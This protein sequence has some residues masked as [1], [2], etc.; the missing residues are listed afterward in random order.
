MNHLYLLG[1]PPRTAKS[2][3][4]SGIAQEKG[5]PLIATDAVQE[6]LRNVFI[7]DP[8]QML[9]GIEFE[10]TAEYKTSIEGGGA[11]KHFKKHS[12]EADLTREAILGML[13][14]Y[15]RNN[16]SVA[17]EGSLIT[18]LWAKELDTEEFIVHA[19]FAGY[20]QQSH[21]EAILAFARDNPDDWVAQWLRAG[22]GD[23]TRIRAWVAKQSDQCKK[24]QN[25]AETNDF[26]FFDIST[27]PY[28]EYIASSREYFRQF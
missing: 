13:D 22:N 10:G 17:I 24:L 25:E 21:A 7:N 3:I 23:E 16:T 11:K 15:A 28:K 4:M 2:T 6:G 1:G 26:P 5:I 27:Q 18:P 8:Y 20:T 9:R 12:T 14:H 19:A